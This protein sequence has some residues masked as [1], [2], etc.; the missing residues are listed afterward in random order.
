MSVILKCRPTLYMYPPSEQRTEHKIA[1]L[2][3]WR[4]LQGLAPPHL[5]DLLVLWAL[6]DS[7]NLNRVFFMFLL[8]LQRPT[9]AMY[10][11]TYLQWADPNFLGGGLQPVMAS[12]FV[13]ISF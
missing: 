4:C 5:R 2:L 9:C 1:E 6:N 10:M 8:P 11:Y 12:L 7:A 3:V 13:L